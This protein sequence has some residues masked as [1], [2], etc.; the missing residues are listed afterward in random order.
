MGRINPNTFAG[1]PLDRASQR[2]ADEA[3]IAAAKADSCERVVLFRANQP[4]LAGPRRGPKEVV[5]LGPAAFALAP[6]GRA[7]A[8]LGL[9]RGE[10]HFALDLD[11]RFDL[12][13]SP[14]EGLGAF[15]DLRAAALDL[16]A[17]EASILASAKSVLD[18]HRRHGWCA[19]CGS[20][21]APAD[22]GWKRRCEACSAEHFPRT[23]PVAIMLATHGDK[24]LLGR[25]KA[26]PAR[27]YSA[28]AGFVEPG[29]TVEEAC[30][31]ELQEEAGVRV[32]VHKVR[33]LFAQPWPYPSSLMFGLLAETDSLD[34]NPDGDEI[35]EVRWLTRAEAAEVLDGRHR[36]IVS[37]PRMA[38]A[39]QILRAWVE[40]P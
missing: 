23:D 25:Q 22:A 8:F 28:L 35:D 20:P 30:V 16:S 27:F 39:H 4:L 2:R 32:S 13:G 11:D 24:C 17:E 12:E 18:W 19:V 10:P 34:V 26:W 7:W 38:I 6:P 31:R 29:E 15:E 14:I 3:F 33:Y 40:G 5:W 21:T 1:N 37:P 36:E 9:A